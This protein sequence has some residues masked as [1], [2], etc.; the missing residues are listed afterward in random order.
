MKLKLTV[1][2]LLVAVSFG[3][4]AAFA[5]EAQ[6]TLPTPSTAQHPAM[7][8]KSMQAQM[9]QMR[10]QMEQIQAL[11]KDSMAKM[12]SADEAMKTHMET[13]KDSMKSQMELQHAVINQLQNMADHMKMMM[14][15]RG[16]MMSGPMRNK[17]GPGAENR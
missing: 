11:M 8:M 5:Q 7:D 15:N 2:L 13:Q 9:D 3:V 1:M 6:P 10:T 16:G 12:A 4:P 17:T 14:A